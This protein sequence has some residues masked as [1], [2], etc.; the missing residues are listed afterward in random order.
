MATNQYFNNFP[1]GQITSEQLLVEDLLI[2]ALQ[3]Y[4]MDVW[5]LPRETDD[6][7]D[8]L[9]GE[10]QLKKYVKA[11]PLEM[12]LYDV[13]GM[14]GAGDFIS[15]FGLE[16]PDEVTFQVSRRRF[17]AS[18]PGLIRA[19]EGDLVYVPLVQNFFEITFVEHE[20]PVAQFY[21]LG[22][23]RDANVYLY[24][25]KMKQ[26]VFSQE[27]IQTGIQEIDKQVIDNYQATDLIFIPG[28]T[29][30]FDVANNESV[31]QG[32]SLNTATAFANVVSWNL[33]T[34]TLGVVKVNGV[35]ANN[36][37][38]IGNTSN[39]RWTLASSD[40]QTPMDNM[41]EDMSDNAQLQ[42]EG[43]AILDFTEHNPFGEP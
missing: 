26:F 13:T 4:G 40:D 7:F 16:I 37:L 42:T 35:F 34:Q 9:M 24:M 32:T 6:S 1:A 3:I 11:Y 43:D 12:Y 33:Q 25:L 36:S 19:R 22:R 31:Y 8:K 5:Y 20:N 17:K 18:V 10:D 41:F 15:K 38:V 39:A 30:N 21:T 14:E 27:I 2:E 28:G 23:G 29:G